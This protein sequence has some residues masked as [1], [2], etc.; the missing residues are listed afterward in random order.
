MHYKNEDDTPLL[1]DDIEYD[2]PVQVAEIE[3]EEEVAPQPIKRKRKKST[4]IHEG[5][6]RPLAG[7]DR[8][9]VDNT[10][11]LHALSTR[12]KIVEAAVSA[13][14]A[15]PRV[16]E[17][18][19]SCLLKIATNVAKKRNFARYP[20]REEMI[21]DAVIACINC[22]DNFDP[23]IS[24]NPF[25]YF[26][27]TCNYAF[28][29]RIL[30]EKKLQYVKYKSTLESITHGNLAVVTDDMDNSHLFDNVR[31]ETEYMSSFVDEFEKKLQKAAEEQAP[32]VPQKQGLELFFED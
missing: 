28:I 10:I 9:Y 26:T 11:F 7:Q 3:D 18:I 32:Q 23:A 2:V 13:G 30:Y 5:S 19:G 29:N 17:F 24:S 1:S 25:S 22:V 4:I 12:R 15:I 31:L 16:S 20:Y 27:Q 14:E 6:D 8:H 21:S